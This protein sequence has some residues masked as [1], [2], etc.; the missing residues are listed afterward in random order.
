MKYLVLLLPFVFAVPSYG[1]E[2]KNIEPE[3]KPPD[4]RV[5]NETSYVLDTAI[6]GVPKGE[7]GAPISVWGWLQIRPGACKTINVEKGTPRF[8]YARS[9]RFHQGGIREWRGRFEHC[10]G[11]G[12]F[13]AKTGLAC[14][15]QNK[16]PAKFLQIVPTEERTDFV[17]AEDFGKK[18]ET[19]GIQ[20]L[21][22][23]NNYEIKRIDGLTGKRTS[24]ILRAFLKDNGLKTNIS[25]DEQFK[26]LIKQAKIA[27]KTT[28][29][30]LCNKS[31]AKIWSAVAFLDGDNWQSRGWWPIEKGECIHPFTENLKNK[32]VH[33]Y[34]RLE[35]G[36]KPDRI[37]KTKAKTARK[38]CV[39][40]SIFA[41]LE[42]EF[43]RDQGYI[44]ANFRPVKTEKSGIKIELGDADFSGAT[45]TG[46]R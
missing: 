8:I 14:D 17:E 32:N 25:K 21:L 19:A 24:K 30:R 7:E 11:D 37:I 3:I 12:D 18:A 22:K 38:F 41:A 1:Q 34:A 23:D 9:A 45:I 16:K 26:M 39:G 44:A 13:T 46:L 35:N 2:N 36:D 31:S 5:C 6:A 4:W 10:I 33:Y 42:H 40:P 15:L 29:L 28:G 27:R 43:C 20:R